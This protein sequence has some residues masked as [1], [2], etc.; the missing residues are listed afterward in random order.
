LAETLVDGVRFS[1]KPVM[2]EPPIVDLLEELAES[3][4]LQISYEPI[5]LD[6]ELGSRPGGVCLFKGQRLVIINPH[7]SLKEKIKILSEAVRHFDLDQ[8]YI[9]PVLRELLDSVAPK[10]SCTT[11][12]E[13]LDSEE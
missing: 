11:V 6:E 3:F 4:G 8:I 7:A 13:P 1:A 5:K 9:R 10:P 12:E 2:D